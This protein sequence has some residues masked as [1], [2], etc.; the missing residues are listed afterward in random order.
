MPKL[1]LRIF[2]GLSALL[3]MSGVLCAQGGFPQYCKTN[4]G[5][6][7]FTIKTT[8][9]SVK[10]G[11]PCYGTKDGQRYDGVAVMSKNDDSSKG[12]FP[13]YCKTNAGVLGPYQNN[14][15]KVGEPC[16]G[17]KDGQRYDGVAVMRKSGN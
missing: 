10:V 2:T 4:A 6:F 15:V 13:Q 14:S 3:M 16:Y 11:E 5:V 9:P 1:S 7:P 8:P 12:G 17:T